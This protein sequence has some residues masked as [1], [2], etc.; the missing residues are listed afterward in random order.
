MEPG[1]RNKAI[2]LICILILSVFLSACGPRRIGY[3]VLLWSPNEEMI[4]TGSIVEV[5]E[6]SVIRDS[7]SVRLMDAEESLEIDKWRISFY[8]DLGPAETERD[9]FAESRLLFAKTDQNALPVREEPNRLSDRVYKLRENEIMKVLERSI[10]ETDEDGLIGSWYKVLTAEG[11]VGY[12]F[13]YY[14]TIFDLKEGTISEKEVEEDFFLQSFLSHPWRP[15]EFLE[16]ILNKTINLDIIKPEIGLFP[17]PEEKK[18]TLVTPDYTVDF[19]YTNIIRIGE[20]KYIFEGSSLQLIIINEYSASIQYNYDGSLY[21]VA[22]RNI[23]EDIR[24]IIENEQKRRLDALNAFLERGTTLRSEAYGQ[25]DMSGDWGFAWFG[26]DRLVPRVIDGDAGLEGQ[27]SFHIFNSIEIEVELQDIISFQFENMDPEEYV[28]FYY[29]FSGMDVRF[30][31]IPPEI[32]EDDLVEDIVLNP[33]VMVFT[34][35]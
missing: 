24:D 28:S 10:E 4:E 15:I 12:C 7:Y 26:Y 3:G 29:E 11:V 25:I 14:L 32:I 17:Y 27:V 34:F 16:L 22:Y 1:Y 19:E 6:E 35:F 20:N 9:G 30:T 33:I 21:S 18:L 8:K 23:V 31:Y 2:C 5:L 13:D